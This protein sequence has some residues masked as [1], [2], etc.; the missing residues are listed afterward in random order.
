MKC[1]II[2][3]KGIFLPS[4]KE[5][6]S[7]NFY[8]DFE[9][10][11]LDMIWENYTYFICG[12]K[13]GIESETA[14]FISKIKEEEYQHISLE[15]VLPYVPNTQNWRDNCYL[16]YLKTTWKCDKKTIISTQKIN[17][18]EKRDQYIIDQSD[19]LLFYWNGRKKGGI[20][21][22][23]QYAQSC[24]KSLRFIMLH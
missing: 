10:P 15:I 20:W 3:N 9:Q 16:D 8:E 4:Y 11:I 22:S 6:Y 17:S 24:G 23:I 18:M 13:E 7:D 5:K 21:K 19:T 14:K 12:F 1:G 2:G